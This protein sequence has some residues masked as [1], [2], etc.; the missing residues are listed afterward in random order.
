MDLDPSE[1][2]EEEGRQMKLP[3]AI[4]RKVLRKPRR[5]CPVVTGWPGNFIKLSLRKGS[6]RDILLKGEK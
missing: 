6:E 3:V 2:G 4:H 1:M 5:A